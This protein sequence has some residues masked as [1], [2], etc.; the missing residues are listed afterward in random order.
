MLK[1]N[2]TGIESCRSF[3]AL[4]L[5][6][7]STP[8]WATVATIEPV[9]E[10]MMNASL[11]IKGTVLNIETSHQNTPV[12]NFVKSA[13]IK[14]Q[15]FESIFTTYT[16]AKEEVIKGSHELN[17]FQVSI[18]GGCDLDSGICEEHLYEY[19]L[20]AGTEK[21]MFLD[22]NHD[23][24]AYQPI[25][26]IDSAFETTSIKSLNPK[27]SKFNQLPIAII[28]GLNCIYLDCHAN[29]FASWDP[30]GQIVNYRWDTPIGHLFGPSQFF[31][32]PW[33]GTHWVSL[34]V[35]D[36]NNATSFTSAIVTA[37]NPPT[38]I[39]E[40]DYDDVGLRGYTDD[41]E[42]NAESLSIGQ[43]QLHNF[44]DAGDEDWTMVWSSAARAYEFSTQLI[45]ANADTIAEVY[46]VTDIEVNPNFPGQNRFIIN[47]MQL[48]GSDT[49]S[50]H[51]SVIFN[52]EAGF[53]YVMKTQ[54][55]TNS[56][57]NDTD[58]EVFLNAVPI[59]ADQYDD[60]SVRG[61]VDD[62]EGDAQSLSAGQT[63]W[64]NF[65]DNGDQDWTMVWSS[66]VRDYRFSAEMIGANSD[67][68]VA[69]YK[70]TDIVVNPNYPNQNRFIINAMQHVGSANNPGTS[71]VTFTSEAGF[72]YVMK[73]ES[74]TNSYGA[75]TEYKSQLEFVTN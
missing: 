2:L 21:I 36:N 53:L 45:G 32:V 54:S 38:P 70:V 16:F 73:T 18:K 51:S 68:K 14:D 33:G 10:D 40:D 52:S 17:T 35:T 7:I 15:G 62:Y 22:Y 11:I 39:D 9:T 63:Q 6:M 67:A 59:A 3:G 69:V 66:T 41:Y 60:V 25:Q 5:V 48:V 56:F 43:S 61:Y 50:G 12:Q 27:G 19:G 44:H 57:G 29:A 34:W 8:L 1:P 42:G 72:L 20:Q 75:G 55:R 46:K 58:Y 13:A 47:N 23:L 31:R 24:Q 37:F 26:E 65:H 4:L 30:D 64:H 49:G 28:S 74:R 71:S